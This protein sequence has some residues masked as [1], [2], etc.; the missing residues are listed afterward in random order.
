MFE[1][2]SLTRV[3]KELA[4]R[5]TR[6]LRDMVQR[7]GRVCRGSGLASPWRQVQES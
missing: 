3:D 4:E 2:S 1:A 5:Q 6:S 7:R